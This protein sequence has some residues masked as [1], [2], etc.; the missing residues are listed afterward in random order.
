MKNTIS[1]MLVLGTFAAFSLQAAAQT[2]SLTKPN[3]TSTH[4]DPKIT[5][6]KNSKVLIDTTEHVTDSLLNKKKATRN[7]NPSLPKDPMPETKKP[8]KIKRAPVDSG[9]TAKP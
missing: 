1:L 6:D 7:K 8:V 9:R 4:R 3:R 2:D 5:D